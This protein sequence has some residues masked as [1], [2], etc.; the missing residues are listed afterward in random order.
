MPTRREQLALPHHQLGS[1]TIEEAL[2]HDFRYIDSLQRHFVN[3]TGF[4]PTTAIRNHLDRKS[5]SLLTINGDPVG[6]SMSSGGIR[7]PHRLIQIAIQEDAWRTG[8][9][10]ALIHLSLAKAAT[11]PQAG[12]TGT[13][14]E[15]LVVNA[16]VLSTGAQIAGYDTRPKARKRKLIHYKWPDSHTPGSPSILLLDSLKPH[17]NRTSD[18]SSPRILHP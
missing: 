11:M 8:L 18:L 4:V 3:S 5:Y 7:K 2:P 15:G 12:M 10:T 13:V 17:D 1:V 9:G 16:C 6:Y 14:R